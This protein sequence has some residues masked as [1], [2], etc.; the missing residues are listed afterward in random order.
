[1]EYDRPEPSSV[2]AENLAQLHPSL[3]RAHQLGSGLNNGNRIP[4]GFYDLDQQ[5]PGGGWP[6]CNLIE[7]LLKNYGIGELRFLLPALRSLVAERKQLVFMNPPFLPLPNV[8]EQ[9]GIPPELV[10][11]IETPKPENRLWA[12]EKLIQSDSCGALLIWL[13]KESFLQA[14]QLRRLQYQANKSRGLCI[15][16]RPLDA[17][18]QPSPASLRLTLIAHSPSVLKVQLI[19]RRGPVMD[20]TLLLNLPIQFLPDELLHNEFLPNEFLPIKLPVQNLNS[21][22]LNPNNLNQPSQELENA[23]DFSHLFR[24]IFPSGSHSQNLPGIHTQG[25]YP[26]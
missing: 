19:K 7:L 21:Q 1:M 4:S 9:H 10:V 23:M 15:V 5:L 25:L 18:K 26:D 17:Q 13:P 20:S 22:S 16:F 3:W 2:V 11:L 24:E 12:I 8:L 14:H 6:S